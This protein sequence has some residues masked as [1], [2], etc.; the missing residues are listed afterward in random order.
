MEEFHPFG[1]REMYVGD[2]NITE[3]AERLELSKVQAECLQLLLRS[4][5]CTLWF[6]EDEKTNEGRIDIDFFW[7]DFD[8]HVSGT[9]FLP[10]FMEAIASN[11]DIGDEMEI[12]V[13]E[14]FRTVIDEAIGER[15]RNLETVHKA[16]S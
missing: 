6:Q 15:R 14:K 3:L 1:E 11:N 7:A 10:F 16:A 8:C 9:N 5:K 2:F 4:L 12:D 13:L